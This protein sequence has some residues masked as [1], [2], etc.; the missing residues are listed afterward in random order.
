[1]FIGFEGFKDVRAIT[2]ALAANRIAKGA[3]AESSPSTNG[4][5]S[6]RPE[7]AR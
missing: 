2:R 7:G 3:C 1:M 6:P 5:V 4:V